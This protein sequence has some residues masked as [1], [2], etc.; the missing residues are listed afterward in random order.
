MIH[1]LAA[2]TVDP[3]GSA[4]FFV[5]NAA[6]DAV[7][8]RQAKDHHH[9]RLADAREDA[10]RSLAARTDPADPFAQGMLLHM[11]LDWRWDV[12]ALAPFHERYE[13]GDWFHAYREQIALAG[14]WL[15]HNMPWNESLWQRILAC[16]PASYG[17]VP[18]AN[19]E[20]VAALLRHTY[21][22]N[23]LCPQGVSTHFPPAYVMDF[24]KT[25]AQLYR[26][27]R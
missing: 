16:P 9:Y 22:W 20:Q 10:L 17:A 12:E 2:H 8:T 24:A 3:K 13:G 25:A 27:W 7:P 15:F 18:G 19:A 11:F 5:G 23:R 6:P 21:D 26:A 14:A 4:L 1:L